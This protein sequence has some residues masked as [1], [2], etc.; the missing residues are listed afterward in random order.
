MKDYHKNKDSTYLKYWD[1]NNIYV[2]A[3]SK[4]LPVDNF[5]RVV[6]ASQF[7]EDSIESIM[8]IV[9]NDICLKLMLMSKSRRTA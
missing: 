9:V 6:E 7:N 5:K 3:M 1:V 4:K 8:K 2:Q